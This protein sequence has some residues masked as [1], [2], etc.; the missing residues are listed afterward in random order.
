LNYLAIF[1]S[2]LIFYE[3][4]VMYVMWYAESFGPYEY[5]PVT[6]SITYK[7]VVNLLNDK[8]CYQP[9]SGPTNLN[10]IF[11][12]NYYFSV[13]FFSIP[14]KFYVWQCL[15]LLTTYI[16]KE[17]QLVDLPKLPDPQLND[18]NDFTIKNEVSW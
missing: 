15:L 18:E 5:E 13:G 8:L 12:W 14:N 11:D 4:F 9:S 16:T 7:W 1:T 10:C 2:I 17:F 3:Y 6:E